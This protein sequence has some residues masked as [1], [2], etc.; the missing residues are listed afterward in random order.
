MGERRAVPEAD[1]RVHDR[2]RMDDD[3]DRSYGRPNRKCVS[4][5]SSP[6]FASVAESMVIFG[7]MLQVGWARASS[8]ESRRPAPPPSFPRNGPPDAVRTIESTCSVV[9]PS[10]HWKIA[11]CSLSTGS[12]RPPPALPGD[13]ARDR[14]RRR[15][16]PCWRGRGR[17]RARAPRA[18]RAD[19]RTRRRRSGRCR[20]PLRSSSSTRSPPTCVRGASPS[21]DRDARGRGDELETRV[22]RDDLDRLSTDRPGGPE[23]GNPPCQHVTVT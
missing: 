4:I 8:A 15:D 17:P 9:R 5:S 13:E 10:R 6:L 16:S 7:P 21:I 22:R 3:L 23:Q 19:R 1:E 12:R 14:R 11:E 18:S 20:A 2:C